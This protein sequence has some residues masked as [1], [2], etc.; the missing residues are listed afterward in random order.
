VQRAGDR[1]RINVQLI[2]ARTDA[3][4]WPRATTAN[5]RPRTSSPSRAR[6]RRRSPEHSRP[7][8]PRASERGSTPSRRTASRPGRP[9]SWASSG[10]PG[11]P[12]QRW[13]KPRRLPPCN[14]VRPEVRTRPR[15]LA[16]SPH[17]ADRLDRRTTRPDAGQSPAVGGY[18]IETRSGPVGCLGCS[19]HDRWCAGQLAEAEKLLRRALELD[20]NNSRPSSRWRRRS[21][22]CRALMKL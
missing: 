4:L 8:S 22:S 15:G 11:G 13:A 9:T 10:S 19:G 21:P 3:H 18:G 6:W 17:L 2:D 12:P 7:R 14:R 5:S 1:V 16:R 20:R